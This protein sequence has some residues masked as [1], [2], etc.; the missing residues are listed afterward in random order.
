MDSGNPTKS[1]AAALPAVSAPR[2]RVSD[3][4]REAGVS[5]ATVDRVLHGRP[6]VRHATVQKVLKAAARLEYL[7]EEDFHA[8][9]AAP[10]QLAFLLP[11]GT[12]RY[13]RMLG[14]YIGYAEDVWSP[15]NT[16][17]RC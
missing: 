7:P 15:F 4:A 5:T 17:C 16:R 10:M 12:N 13:L 8:R 6:N 9:A 1:G 2:A 3:V 11:A 14:D